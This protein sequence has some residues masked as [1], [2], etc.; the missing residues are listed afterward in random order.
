MIVRRLEKQIL[1]TLERSPS[2]ALVG[3]RQVGKTTIALNISENIP[4]VYLDLEDTT[5]LEK[6][7]DIVAFHAENHQKLIILDEVQRMPEIFSQL[8]GIIDRERRKGN[9]SGQFLF[10]GSASIDLLQQPG[11]SLAGRIA[12]LELYGI[13]TLEYA[14]NDQLMINNIWLRGGFPESLLSVSDRDSLFW[15]RDFIKTYLARDIPQLGPRIPALTLERFW[16]ML[17]HNQGGVLNASQLARNLEVTSV[18]VGRYL[19]LMADLLLVR[20]LQPWTFNVG[21]RLVRA[22]KVYV[23]DSGI[24]HAL[25]NISGFNDLLGH[26]VVGGSWEGFVIENILSVAPASALP[27][28]YRTAD[29]AEIDLVLEFSA[30]EKWAVEIKRSSAP[31]LSK[32][33]HIACNDIKADKRYV[34]YSGKDQFPMADGVTAISLAALMQALLDYQ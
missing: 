18:T 12:Y 32:G 13:D 14:V 31:A 23:R 26:P 24:T 3:P 15:R 25:L 5:D 20:R 27:F 21:K 28:F 16:T 34:V 1:K 2:V 11:E 4:S 29:G 17:A 9:K 10:L 6:V 33:F 8:R 19:D 22:P 7:R 30:K